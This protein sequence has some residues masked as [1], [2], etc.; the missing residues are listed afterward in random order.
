MVGGGRF[1]V[2][3]QQ[4]R[5]SFVCFWRRGIGGPWREGVTNPHPE[6][7]TKSERRVE[8]CDHPKQNGQLM[9]KHMASTTF[10]G[11]GGRM[12]LQLDVAKKSVQFKYKNCN[13]APTHSQ[14]FFST[15]GI[16]QHA[17]Y[18]A[19]PSREQGGGALQQQ[20]EEKTLKKAPVNHG[21]SF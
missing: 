4:L 20:W 15:E 11:G 10:G 12:R 7:K 3:D 6:Q 2:I 9:R 14:F 19:L 13:N 18:P 16:P 1:Q 21:V 17:V 5:V 8:F